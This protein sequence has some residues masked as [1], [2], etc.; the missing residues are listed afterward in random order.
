MS[1]FE[2]ITLY[3]DQIGL[4]FTGITIITTILFSF[5]VGM[6]LMAGRLHLLL[7]MVLTAVFAAVNFGLASGM[8]AAGMRAASMGQQIVQR[9]Q[10]EGSEI[11]WMYSGVIPEPFPRNFL[12]FFLIA[13]GLAIIFAF[14]RRREVSARRA[15]MAANH[16]AE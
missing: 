2:L 6:Y 5:V 14:I 9:V 12:Y 1:D 16:S 10:A 4:F 8:Y 7:L 3:N 11:A 13:N 15:R